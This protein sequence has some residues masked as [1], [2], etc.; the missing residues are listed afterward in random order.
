MSKAKDEID[1]CIGMLQYP[2]I[3]GH[4]RDE[5]VRNANPKERLVSFTA[6]FDAPPRLHQKLSA[7]LRDLGFTVTLPVRLFGRW[8]FLNRMRISVTWTSETDPNIP[9]I[10]T[11]KVASYTLRKHL[12]IGLG[13][14]CLA[15]AAWFFIVQPL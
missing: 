5:I 8:Q 2:T 12:A 13:Y 10:A 4:C 1:Q 6:E 9:P 15:V 7:D 11:S 14:L 3:L